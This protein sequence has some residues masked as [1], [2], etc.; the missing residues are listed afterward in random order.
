MHN[1]G[2][3]VVYTFAHGESQ[4]HVCREQERVHVHT[5][6]TAYG[7]ANSNWYLFTYLMLI[8]IQW[9]ETTK[10]SQA[11]SVCVFVYER[12]GGMETC[13]IEE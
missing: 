1:F 13:D 7:T 4:M 5:K 6:I 11:Y 8:G 12:S 10:R 3:G 9:V 2:A